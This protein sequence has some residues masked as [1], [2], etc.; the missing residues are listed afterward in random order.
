MSNQIILKNRVALITGGSQ[1][2]GAVTAITLSSM[3]PWVWVSGRG[4][5]QRRRSSDPERTCM[6][7]V[8]KGTFLCLKSFKRKVEERHPL[9]KDYF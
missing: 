3:P 1:G 5:S 8:G 2:I 4:S 9:N 7:E 6:L